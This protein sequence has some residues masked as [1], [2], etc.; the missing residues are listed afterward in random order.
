MSYPKLSFL[1][2]LIFILPLTIF[3][4]EAQN[5]QPLPLEFRKAYQTNSRSV[6]GRP[7]S[8]YWQNRSD[9]TIKAELFPEKKLLKGDENITY[10]NN[11]PDSLNKIVIRLYPDLFKKGG[12]RDWPLD[13]TALTNGTLI[14]Y[15][16]IKDKLIDLKNRK[17]AT[18]SPT[19]LHIFLP[20]KLAP[21]DSLK[22]SIGW[23]FTIP[24]KRP[25]RTGYYGDNIY[26]I[27]YWYPQIAVYDDID[28]WDEI[29]YT[30]TVE[31]Y[32]DFNNYDVALKTPGQFMV[33]AT[34]Q[35]QN[36]NEIFTP[37]V[38]GKLHK[39]RQ[40]VDVVNIFT[41]DDCK[42]NDVLKSNSGNTWHFTAQNIPDFSFGTINEAN[43]D[44]SSV[45]VD[46][47][48]NRKVFVEAIYPD[49]FRTFDSAAIWGRESV[50]YMSKV[51]PAYPFPYPKMTLFDNGRKG[52]GM[53]SPMMVN[54]GDPI[55]SADAAATTFHEIAHTYFPFFMGINE[56]KYA[57]MDEGWA[58]F[59]PCGFMQKYYP[60]WNY[61]LR[62]VISFENFNG[63]ERESNLMTLSYL[64]SAYDTYRNHAYN[65]S[66][67]AYYFLN[68]ALGDSL[69]K[70]ALHSYMTRWHEKHPVPYDFFNTFSD[71]TGQNLDWYFIPWFYE[72][73]FADQGIR[74]VTVNNKIVIENIG[75]LPLPVEVTVIFNDGSSEKYYQNTSTWKSG[76][77][78]VIVQANPDKKIDQIILGSKNIPDINKS[79]NEFKAG[80]E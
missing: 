31:F 60:D 54:L 63:K 12:V 8:S 61:D 15:I 46:S 23:Q 44:G 24:E 20:Q 55:N 75:G 13:S 6:D 11:S 1:L 17:M 16:R 59:L 4:T 51:L 34:G 79:N 36:E 29:E 30:G 39:A 67:M 56:R 64:L 42:N 50:E 3:K 80:E 10:F 52:G 57:W 74:K 14:E 22:L 62:R 43:W 27:A 48:S 9:Y 68:D 28:G 65:R 58:A 49:N 32:N 45:V 70:F 72:R 78:A 76:N 38:L 69:F 19:N 35:L 71:A 26:F 33:W 77:H 66:S 21:H 53:E 40:S 2:C 41:V 73:S 47:I 7:G 25:V 5:N 37:S 18:R